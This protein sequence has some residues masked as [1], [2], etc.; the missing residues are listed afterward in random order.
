[1]A[2]VRSGREDRH[3]RRG[4]V[5]MLRRSCGVVGIQ[6]GKQDCVTAVH[7]TFSRRQDSTPDFLYRADCERA[8]FEELRPKVAFAVQAFGKP[9]PGDFD[10]LWIAPDFEIVVFILELFP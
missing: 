5:D 7:R 3:L 10:E 4:E 8:P 6:Y 1:M 2:L 9:A